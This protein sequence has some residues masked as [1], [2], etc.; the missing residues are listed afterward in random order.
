MGKWNKMKVSKV[1]QFAVGD[2]VFAKVKGY[3]HWPAEVRLQ[4]LITLD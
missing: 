4:I 3:E 2:Y 1:H